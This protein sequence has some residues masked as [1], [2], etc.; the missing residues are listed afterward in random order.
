MNPR[1]TLVVFGFL[2]IALAACC[3]HHPR[4]VEIPTEPPTL[5]FLQEDSTTRA[6]VLTH[7]GLPSGRFLDDRILTY[8]LDKHLEIIPDTL[9]TAAPLAPMSVERYSLVL[10]F[11]PAGVLRRHRLIRVR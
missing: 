5:V 11:D 7:L 8:R 3:A 9:R 1:H 10:V 6:D 2:S 4:S